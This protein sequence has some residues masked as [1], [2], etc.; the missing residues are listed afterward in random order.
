MSAPFLVPCLV[1]LRAEFDAVAPGR[2]R[3]ADGWIGDPAHQ[4]RTSDHN[5]RPDGAVLAL[6]I[7]ST[8]PWPGGELWFDDAVR[9]IVD[10]ER[11]AWLS[12]TGV[13]RLQYVIWDRRI[14]H[15]DDDLAWKPYT[16]SAD[17][18]TGHA[19]FS[20]RHNRAGNTAT[21]PWGL[22]DDMTEEQIRE[23]AA[24]GFVDVLSRANAAARGVTTDRTEEQ[25]KGDRQILAMLRAAVGGPT[26]LTG[27][28]D[29]TAAAVLTA[30]AS[31]GHTAAEVAEALS[32]ALGPVLSV[33]VGRILSGA[34]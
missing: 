31:A 2:V 28:P 16:G 32:V 20:A 14:A 12:P 34:A 30:L 6:D 24:L 4:A 8:G 1:T 17:P 7:D 5:P 25:A 29:A 26:D 21:A 19:H 13:C 15:I 10:R 18:H 27:L 9:S 22:E 23:A 11:E 33:E 3:G